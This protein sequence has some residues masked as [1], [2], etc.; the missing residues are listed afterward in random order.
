MIIN[1]DIKTKN[2]TNISLPFILNNF[3][4]IF[5]NY[6][7]VIFSCKDDKI[8]DIL[9]SGKSEL[10]FFDADKS[11]SIAIMHYDDVYKLLQNMTPN[12]MYINDSD[13]NDNL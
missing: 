6:E 9:Y 4:N 7:I 10:R 3:S 13:E 8:K 2:I 12:Y 5:P 11:T 1:F